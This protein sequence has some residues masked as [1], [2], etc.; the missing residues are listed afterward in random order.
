MEEEEAIASS[1]FYPPHLRSSVKDKEIRRKTLFLGVITIMA[2]KQ[3]RAG[4]E[5]A[6]T[7]RRK[8]G[9][10]AENKGFPIFT[11]KKWSGFFLYGVP[12][13]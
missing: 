3:A 4:H 13:P 12:P 9:G 7:L 11:R 2:P 8:K 10:G 6:D 1:L 5:K